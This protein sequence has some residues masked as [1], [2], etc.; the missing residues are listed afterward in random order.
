[1]TYIIYISLN[2]ERSD[3]VLSIVFN[4]DNT[5]KD[6]TKQEIGNIL[7]AT[8]ISQENQNIKNMVKLAKLQMIIRLLQV[9]GD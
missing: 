4:S 9:F 1:M 2:M 6:L 8:K 3:L 5:F 7:L